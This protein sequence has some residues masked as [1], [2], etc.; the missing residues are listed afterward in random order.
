MIRGRPAGPLEAVNGGDVRMVERRENFGFALKPG[1]PVRV[2]GHRL[3]QHLDRHR[4]LQVGVRG[5]IDLT[6]SART[7]VGSDVI[8]T[9]A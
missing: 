9:E 5:A 8:R 3:G 4:P 2:C 1:E 6:H 7:N